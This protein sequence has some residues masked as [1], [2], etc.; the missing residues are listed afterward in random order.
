ML[1]GGPGADRGGLP[2]VTTRR[3]GE[4]R[5]EQR[6][7][8]TLNPYMDVILR[9]LGLAGVFVSFGEGVCV[10]STCQPQPGK[11]DS[12]YPATI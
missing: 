6:G 12:N 1:A 2:P 8:R 7:K 10:E 11:P 4:V 5:W 9:L 3:D